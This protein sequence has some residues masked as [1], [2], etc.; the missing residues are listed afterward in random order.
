MKPIKLLRLTSV[1]YLLIFALLLTVTFTVFVKF[2]QLGVDESIDEILVNRKRNVV[3]LLHESPGKLPQSPAPFTDYNTYRLETGQKEYETFKDTLIFDHNDK[4]N[5]VYRKLSSVKKIK[6]EYYKI[7]VFLPLIEEE[8]VTD[9]IVKALVLVFIIVLIMFYLSS[10]F[11][12]KQIFTPFYTILYRLRDFEVHRVAS[13][14]PVSSQIREFSD[15]NNSLVELTSKAYEAFSN[16]KRF[17]ENASHE[18]LTPIAVTQNKLEELAGDRDL[19]DK[20]SQ[21]IQVLINVNQR[22]SRLNKTLLLLSKIENGQYPETQ[23]IMIKPLIEEI[24]LLFEEQKDGMELYTEILVP[25]NTVVTGNFVLLDLLLT[26]L[27]KNAFVHNYKG[28]NIVIDFLNGKLGISNTSFT[29]EIPEEELYKRFYK[30]SSRKES[31]G[32]GLA[33]VKN[34]CT[35]QHWDIRYYHILDRHVFQ[36]SFQAIE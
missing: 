26:N 14:I 7:D 27:I 10:Q 35:V 28:G 1:S 33:I 8:D 32:L 29:K 20:Q 11:L 12:S 19:T 25:E 4:E 34:I 9:S 36:L 30:N 2:L 6:G 23:K 31:W 16:Q 24:L 5:Y 17:I 18:L 13:Y 3:T 21:L 15:L 22:M